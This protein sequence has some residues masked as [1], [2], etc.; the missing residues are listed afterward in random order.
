MKAALALVSSEPTPL[1][2]FALRNKAITGAVVTLSAVVTLAE[3]LVI[4][5]GSFIV[6]LDSSSPMALLYARAVAKAASAMAESKITL[7]V[8]SPYIIKPLLKPRL[9]E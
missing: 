7:L 8:F 6:H 3:N 4:R 9:C 2:V 5:V 1:S